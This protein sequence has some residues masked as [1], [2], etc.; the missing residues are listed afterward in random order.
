MINQLAIILFWVLAILAAIQLLFLGQF[1]LSLRQYL[2]S[3]ASPAVPYT[4][5]AAIVLCLRGADPFL[6]N[7]IKALTQQD[8]P[9]YELH[10]IIDSLE[11]P[12]WSIVSQTIGNLKQIPITVQTLES[13][14]STC[15]LKCS[16]LI[17]ALSRL[18]SDCE[19]VALVDSDTV[20]ASTWLQELVAPLADSRVGLTTG[21]RWYAPSGNQWGSIVRYLWNSTAIVSMYVFKTPWGG[22]LAV[23]TDFLRQANLL[24]EWN[25]TLCED[26]PL[27]LALQ[28]QKLE[29]KFVPSLVMV[30]YE[31]CNLP[32]FMRW[33]S[34]Q[35][36]LTRLYHPDWNWMLGFSLIASVLPILALILMITLQVSS[37]LGL[38]TD[39][40][41][42]QQAVIW[43]GGGL[44]IF[45][46]LGLGAGLWL[47]DRAI[48][49]LMH[50][51]A[52]PLPTFSPNA[53][54]KIILGIPLS[55]VLTLLLM[56]S[57]TFAR[58]TEWR[59][60]TYTIKASHDIHLVEYRPYRL[61]KLLSSKA[62]L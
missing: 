41:T 5:K 50:S 43:L 16:A 60:I 14:R 29:I 55:Q 12:A 1:L 44:V 51:T 2:A 54:L 21:N 4:P 45:Y 23:R 7:C 8:Y 40:E 36:L 32:S 28:K 9:D 53:L 47:I 59:G 58:H 24:E 19:V 48:R 57:A 22:T 15:S 6:P 37:Q 52:Q 62:S 42:S 27:H 13:P 46:L 33:A 26:V 11:D 10:I 20:P 31:E 18:D 61:A 38:S 49:L 56:L 25:R 17:Q 35:L 30:N 34:R 39:A 3:A